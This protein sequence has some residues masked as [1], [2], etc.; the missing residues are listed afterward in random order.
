M[1]KI[2]V[3]K[4]YLYSNC[5]SNAHTDTLFKQLDILPFEKLVNHIIGILI[6]KINSGCLTQCFNSLFI[7]N[8]SIHDHYTRG[9]NHLRNRK[10]KS[11]PIYSSSYQGLWNV[12]LTNV[13]INVSFA[14]FKKN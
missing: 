7:T 4:S 3:D 8:S 2:N 5:K 13:N 9:N 6:Y 11:E 10:G 12:I 1:A 14:V